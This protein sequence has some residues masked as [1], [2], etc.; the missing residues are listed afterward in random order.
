LQ[1]KTCNGNAHSAR[2]LF[3]PI[4][5]RTYFNTTQQTLWFHV[6]LVRNVRPWKT[7][8]ILDGTPTGN[9]I[10][11]A[12][13]L[14]LRFGD[15][16]TDKYVSRRPAWIWPANFGIFIPKSSDHR[17]IWGLNLQSFRICPEM[18]GQRRR[19]TQTW[20]PETYFWLDSQGGGRL[21][22]RGLNFAVICN[23]FESVTKL[24]R[25]HRNSRIRVWISLRCPRRSLRGR[26]HFRIIGHCAFNV[27]DGRHLLFRRRRRI[28]TASWSASIDTVVAL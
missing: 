20:P 18:I 27:R 11:C 19:V 21:Q 9:E 1:R 2:V 22:T 15:V 6:R 12:V 24:L 16:C 7:Y 13:L 14:L 26:V 25:C 8:R 28:T 17:T 3:N 4:S 10:W 23:N 5:K